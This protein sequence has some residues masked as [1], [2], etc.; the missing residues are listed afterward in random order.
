MARLYDTTTA[1]YVNVPQLRALVKAG[2]NVNVVDAS[3]E[4]SPNQLHWGAESEKIE[5]PT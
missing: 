5:L 4:I 1:D 2:A 3:L